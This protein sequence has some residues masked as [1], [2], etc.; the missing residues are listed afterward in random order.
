MIRVYCDEDSMDHD[1]VRALRSRGLDVTTA[2]A[3]NMIDQDDAAHLE[4]ATTLNRVLF[5]F[6]RGDYYQ[7][8]TEYLTQ[9]KSHSGIILANQQRYSI[10]EAMRRILHLAAAVSPEEMRNRIEFLSV[11]S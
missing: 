8:H 3:E 7:L 5:S 1:L 9:G 10:G 6:N 4:Y 2:L 11:W